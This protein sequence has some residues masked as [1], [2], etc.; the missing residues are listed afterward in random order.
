MFLVF[1]KFFLFLKKFK[2]LNN[3]FLDMDLCM[4]ICHPKNALAEYI[5]CKC[6]E[7]VARINQSK[8]CL[9]IWRRFYKPRE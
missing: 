2:C 8:V 3:F 7:R 6:E 1:L 9:E 5:F 4:I